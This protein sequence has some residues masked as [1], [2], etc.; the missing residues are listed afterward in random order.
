M[1]PLDFELSWLTHLKEEFTKDYFAK[2]NSFLS[3]E[4]KTKTIYPPKEKIFAALN[5]TPLNKVKVVIIGQDPYHGAGQANGLCFSVSDWIKKPASLNNIFKEINSDLGI[6]IPQNGNLE[7]WAKQGVLLLN[8][9]LTLR[10]GEAASHQKRGWETFTDKI[11]K[12]VNNETN[13]V[14]FLLWGN[15]AIAK[16]ELI[17]NKSH[18]VLTSA[19]P[20]P[21][22]RGAFFNNKHF[23]KTNNFLRENGKQEIDWRVE[24]NGLLF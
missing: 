6:N 8:A 1:L 3:V 5:S 16:Q 12:I 4:F 18:L 13:C 10:A 14:V 17:T 22:A 20:S 9:V 24:E 23:S 19:H 2:L 21:L 15:Y 7:C 11:I